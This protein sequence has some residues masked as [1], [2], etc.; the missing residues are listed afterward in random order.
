M[1]CRTFHRKLE[2]Y[3]EG[4]LDFPARFGME[5]HA[6]QCLACEKDISTALNL[7]Q[8]AR[9]MQRTSAPPDFENS[10]LARI[11]VEKARRHFWQVRDLWLFG[12][13]GFSWRVAGVTALATMLM[14]GGLTYYLSVTGTDRSNAPQIAAGDVTKS[15]SARSA[16]AT[17]I[18]AG[19][20][21]GVPRGGVS[22]L[23]VG[24][25]SSLFT[26]SWVTPYADPSDSGFVDILVPVS[27]DRQLIMQLP[28]TIRM[29]FD[30]P[31]REHFIRNVSH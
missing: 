21:E 31:S 1:D 5:R 17:P 26:D 3:L 20:T 23:N 27:G 9:E 28:R 10:L 4:G 2:D 25:L 29:R 16:A 15:P 14:V 22:S 7:R 12:F 24:R 8:M 30:Q 11:Q 6:K 18:A 13:D 19:M